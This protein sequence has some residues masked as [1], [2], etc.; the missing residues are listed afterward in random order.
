[1]A[2]E[3]SQHL[4]SCDELR[5]SVPGRMLVDGL[6]LSLRRGEFIAVLGQNGAGKTLSLLTLAGLREPDAGTVRIGVA[7]VSVM[8]TIQ[9]GPL[10]AYLIE[11]MEGGKADDGLLQRFQISPVIP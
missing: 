10:G 5:V 4:L 3:Q 11:A 1:M 8:G 6:E 2:T 9:P 7:I